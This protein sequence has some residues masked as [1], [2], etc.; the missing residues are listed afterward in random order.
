MVRALLEMGATV[1]PQLK[2]RRL[3]GRALHARGAG[4]A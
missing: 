4:G 3:K 2:V 1:T